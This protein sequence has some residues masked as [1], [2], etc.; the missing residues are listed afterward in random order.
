MDYKEKKRALE[1]E[2][3]KLV[4][5]IKVEKGKSICSDTAY[6]VARGLLQP[7]II[8]KAG[9]GKTIEQ[10]TIEALEAR[11]KVAKTLAKLK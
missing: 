2:I 1:R 8:V 7:V 5:G 6:G 10:A 3:K 4:Q 9:A 11:L